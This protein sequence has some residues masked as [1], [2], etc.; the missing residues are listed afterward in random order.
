MKQ[1]VR[2]QICLLINIDRNISLKTLRKHVL[3]NSLLHLIPSKLN[4][5]I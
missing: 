4:E 5:I 1:Q 2:I 3:K